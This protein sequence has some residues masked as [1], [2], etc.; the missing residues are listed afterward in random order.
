MSSSSGSKRSGEKA[1]DQAW[2][3][4]PASK[5]PR[6]RADLSIETQVNT[7]IQNNL[8]G[9]TSFQIDTYTVNGHARAIVKNVAAKEVGPFKMS[10]CLCLC[11]TGTRDRGGMTDSLVPGPA[12]SHGKGA[13]SLGKDIL[14]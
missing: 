4:D 14:P 6:N 5:R 2:V 13:H 1:L 8:K 11:R 12:R 7:A 3:A 9:F 10:G